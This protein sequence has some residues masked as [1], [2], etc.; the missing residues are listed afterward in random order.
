VCE[1]CRSATVL[2]PESATEL[3]EIYSRNQI[4]ASEQRET[5]N[6]TQ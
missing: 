2:D 3:I 1:I 5:Q 6:Y 4:E